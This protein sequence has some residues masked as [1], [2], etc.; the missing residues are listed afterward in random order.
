MEKELNDYKNLSSN[1]GSEV[2]ILKKK[3]SELEGII[4]SL[5]GDISNKENKIDAQTVNKGDNFV[6][7]F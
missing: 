6:N 4:A 5:K 3:I 2:S 1:Q 7:C